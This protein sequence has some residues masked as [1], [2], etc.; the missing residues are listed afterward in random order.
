MSRSDHL[1]SSAYLGDCF[2]RAPE[3]MREYAY[4]LRLCPGEMPSA[5]QVEACMRVL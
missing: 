3:S 4:R 1:L 2:P 5:N